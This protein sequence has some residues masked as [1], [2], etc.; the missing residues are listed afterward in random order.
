M[1]ELLQLLSL[2]IAVSKERVKSFQFGNKIGMT[3][4]FRGVKLGFHVICALIQYRP[5]ADSLG[6]PKTL[7]LTTS[8]SMQKNTKT[9]TCLLP[10]DTM[11]L[12]QHSWH[13]LL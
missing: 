6:Y 11:N 5:T 12:V 1:I 2:E 7:Y 10:L 8:F 13:W 9:L 3:N 4:L